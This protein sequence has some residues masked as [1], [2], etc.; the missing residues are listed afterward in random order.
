MIDGERVELYPELEAEL[1]R[2]DRAGGGLIVKDE[3]TGKPYS[4]DYMQKVFRRIRVAAGLP[5]G[6]TFTG[7]RHG[8]LTEI[9]DSGADDVRAISGHRTLNV[10][11]IYN[12]ASQE[13]ARR[14]AAKRREHIALVAAGETEE[15]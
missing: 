15:I 3:R 13:K 11:A 12:K 6:M 1:A 8:G 9:G 5:D 7:F 10:T 14:I 4:Y 2:T